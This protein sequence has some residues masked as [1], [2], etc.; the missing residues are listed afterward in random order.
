MFAEYPGIDLNIRNRGGETPLH[1]MARSETP[2]E[3]VRY[4]V[5]RGMEINIRDNGGKTPLDIA[6]AG[7]NRELAGISPVSEAGAETDCLQTAL[8]A[9]NVGKPQRADWMFFRQTAQ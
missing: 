1:F 2:V 5:G 8:P 7:G 3:I 6:E 4:L 9:A